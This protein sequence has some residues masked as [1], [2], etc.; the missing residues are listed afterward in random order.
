M[1]LFAILLCWWH[2]SPVK[3]IAFFRHWILRLIRA[4]MLGSVWKAVM[5][6]PHRPHQFRYSSL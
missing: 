4:P 1:Q 2:S 5:A 6:M 3:R